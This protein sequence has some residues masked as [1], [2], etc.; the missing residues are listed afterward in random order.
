MKELVKELNLEEYIVE[1]VLGKDIKYIFILE[2]PHTDEVKEKIPVVGKSGKS[3]SKVLFDDKKL[4]TTEKLL[5]PLNYGLYE[6]FTIY[7]K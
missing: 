7:L 5:R 4:K 3:M 6:R 2:S 1:D